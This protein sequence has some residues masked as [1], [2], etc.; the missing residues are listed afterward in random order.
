MSPFAR[1]VAF[2]IAG[3]AAAA[4]VVAAA[5]GVGLLIVRPA[6]WAGLLLLGLVGLGVLAGVGSQVMGH[7][8]PKGT[9]LERAAS[10][11]VK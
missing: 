10:P 4:V 2:T 7:W 9:A 3:A 1:V 11:Q 5:L 8:G 6:Y